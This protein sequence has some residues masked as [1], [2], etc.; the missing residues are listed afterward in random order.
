MDLDFYDDFDDDDDDDTEDPPVDNTQS[1][2]TLC[3]ESSIQQNRDV[4]KSHC[5]RFECCFKKDD[6]ISCYEENRQEC[7]EYYICEV[8]YTG[9]NMYI[10]G[11]RPL[12]MTIHKMLL[13][14]TELLN[15][16][17]RLLLTHKNLRM[18][19]LGLP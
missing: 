17:H 16:N 8:F 2:N 10:I 4:C 12:P 3:T 1:F 5:S 14:T 7:E 6:S 11:M 15:H 13:T 9:E 19:S 18:L